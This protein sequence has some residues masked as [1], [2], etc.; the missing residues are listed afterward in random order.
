MVTL[1]PLS[2][3]NFEST[4]VS[5]LATFS[6]FGAHIHNFQ[7][8]AEGFVF[9]TIVKVVNMGKLNGCDTVL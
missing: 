7:F 6:K 8:Q 2:P 9:K 4:N 5:G 3:E 1:K